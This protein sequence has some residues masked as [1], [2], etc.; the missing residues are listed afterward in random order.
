MEYKASTQAWSFALRV[1]VGSECCMHL[2]HALR[3]LRAAH[4]D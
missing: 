2:L 4:S 3:K 1:A